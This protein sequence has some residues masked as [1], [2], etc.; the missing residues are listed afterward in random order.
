MVPAALIDADGEA[1]LEAALDMVDAL[2]PLGDP[3]DDGEANIGV[4]LGATFGAAAM[5]GRTQLTIMLTPALESF[6]LWLEQLVA[7]STGKHGLGVIPVVGEPVA[8]VCATPEH[9]LVVTVGDVDGIDALRASGAPLVELSLSRNFPTSA[10][11]S[12]CGRSRWHSPARCWVS[13]PS[14]SPTSRPPRRRPER[15]S[16]PMLPRHRP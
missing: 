3:T 11:T 10:P 6:G 15:C 5:A 12:C 7:E 9:R 13:T 4:R 8:S 14:T 1:I 16:T 2:E